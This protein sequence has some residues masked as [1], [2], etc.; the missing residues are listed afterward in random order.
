MARIC[1]YEVLFKFFNGWRSIKACNSKKNESK[2]CYLIERK[3]IHKLKPISSI[4]IWI[5]RKEKHK[6]SYK[7]SYDSFSSWS[8]IYRKERV[9][10][11]EKKARTTKQIKK[12][13][14]LQVLM[15]KKKDILFI[16]WIKLYWV[17]SN[18]KEY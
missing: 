12:L 17:R 9:S 10:L 15:I 1:F 11:G 4:K 2:W 8:N 14:I 5:R 7:S 18:Q 13:G 3:W 16:L 6:Y